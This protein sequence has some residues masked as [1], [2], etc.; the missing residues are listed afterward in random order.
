MK[1]IIRIRVEEGEDNQIYNLYFTVKFNSILNMFL[2]RCM[3]WGNPFQI[4]Y[5][6]IY[7]NI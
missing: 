7:V 5:F 4:K 3:G 1:I 2:K 6:K